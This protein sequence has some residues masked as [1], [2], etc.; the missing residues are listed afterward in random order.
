MT[1]WLLTCVELKEEQK[2]YL[3]D[4]FPTIRVASIDLLAVSDYE[5]V[6]ILSAG[7]NYLPL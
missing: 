5:K 6:T 4:N 3:Q 2:T 7:V 1:Q